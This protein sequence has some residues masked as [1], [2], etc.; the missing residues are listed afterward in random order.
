MAASRGHGPGH[1]LPPALP[2]PAPPATRRPAETARSSR[3]AKPQ[4]QRNPAAH[5]AQHIIGALDETT[6]GEIG[7]Y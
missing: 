2:L 3:R 6:T 4:S 5:A 1:D 7:I